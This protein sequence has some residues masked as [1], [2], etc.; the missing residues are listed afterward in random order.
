MNGNYWGGPMSQNMMSSMSMMGSNPFES[1]RMAQMFSP[2]VTILTGGQV[3]TAPVPSTIKFELP[4]M[5][6]PDKTEMPDDGLEKQDE[7]DDETLFTEPTQIDYL[8][9][10]NTAFETGLEETVSE[11]PETVSEDPVSEDP[12]GS[13]I[14]EPSPNP[15]IE[16]SEPDNNDTLTENGVQTI[17]DGSRTMRLRRLRIR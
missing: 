2:T 8:S 15:I 7:P 13:P 1:F 5:G 11:S 4:D 14:P 16:M 17:A 9:T 3:L 6:L 12:F 10:T